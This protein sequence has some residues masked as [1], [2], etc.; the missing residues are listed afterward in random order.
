MKKIALY[1]LILMFTL[2]V[3]SRADEGMWIPLLLSERIDDMQAMGLKLSAEDIYSINNSS[4]KDAIV[5]FGGGCTGEIV[6]ASGLLFTNHH[7]GYSAIQSHSTIESDYL[8]NGFWA[9]SRSEELPNSGL[10]ATIM[11]RM[12]DVTSVVLKGTEKAK[13]E[14]ERQEIIEKNISAIV[15]NA[16]AGTHYEAAV[17][18]FYHGNEFYLVVSE[19]FK[20]IRLVGAPP[21]SIGKF[22]G[23][24]DNWV[25]PRHTGDFAVF[26]I[27]AGKD[28]KPASYSAGNLPY[29]PRKHLAISLKGY[30][31]GDFTF[32]FGYPGTTNSYVPSNE[33]DMV[34]FEGNPVRISLREK[35][36]GIIDKYMNT[37]RLTRIQYSAKY[38][39]IANY[40]KKMIG[41]TQGLAASNAVGK[42]KAQEEEFIKWAAS[43]PELEAKYGQIIP[44][45]NKAYAEIRPL[46]L[47][48]DYL[49]EAGLGIEAI[50][51]AWAFNSLVK[52]CKEKGSSQEAIDKKTEEL[53]KNTVSFF[54]NYN[55]DLDRELF[56]V[57][58]KEFS[59]NAD[60]KFLPVEISINTKKYKN[61]FEIWAT[62][63]YSKS[64]LVSE[65][66]AIHYLNNFKRKD[67]K[68]LENDP[69]LK[70]AVS[71]YGMYFDNLMEPL[72]NATFQIDSLQR[73]YMAGL[74]EMMPEK[75]FYPDAN[76]TLRISY[77]KVEGFAPA[78]AVTYLSHTTVDGILQKEDTTIYDYIVDAKLKE[79]VGKKDYGRYVDKDGTMHVAFISS[80]HTTGGNSG[81]PVLNAYGHLIGINFDRCW[82][83]TMSD[84]H[85]DIT[86]CRNISIDIRY[87][88]FIIDKFAGAGYLIDEMT[89][90]H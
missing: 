62:D 7:C 38:A 86:R 75:Q 60:K 84:Y 12:E 53:K 78:D 30:N 88:L 16:V 15:K 63:L 23:D 65:V 58:M 76:S 41:E 22:G 72:D 1:I 68:K 71:I 33:V 4:L 29:V 20:D 36:L 28:N 37:S 69:M 85:Y 52:L 21:S 45:F 50:R 80:N 17:K 81:S 24:T 74:M 35:R 9:M 13:T 3:S 73:I 59:N 90:E 40:W 77:G 39:S 57:L 19:V 42:K 11:V 18:S 25:W 6:S 56:S 49:L 32:V 5:L 2:P 51:F 14:A 47:A 79:L 44:A 27:Y 89:L 26:R 87:C 34:A 82:E 64:I 54:K 70:L 8:T 66:K 48:L 67:Y 83:G 10:K 61:N 55:Q 31:E 46:N 43:K